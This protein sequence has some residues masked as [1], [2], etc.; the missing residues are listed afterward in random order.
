M[1][2][3]NCK[4][5]V[6]ND[7]ATVAGE[8]KEQVIAWYEDYTGEKVD[9]IEE[10]SMKEQYVLCDGDGCNISEGVEIW[11]TVG[12]GIR[13]WFLSNERNGRVVETPFIVCSFNK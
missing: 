12:E 8:S 6:V 5:W 2:R 7:N 11:K 4:V 3:K 13:D 9:I 1:E 10:G